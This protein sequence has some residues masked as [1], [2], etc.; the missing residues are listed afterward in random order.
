[1]KKYSSLLASHKDNKEDSSLV[2]KEGV[3]QQKQV[4]NILKSAAL[5]S[6]NLRIPKSSWRSVQDIDNNFEQVL[7]EKES[8][9][10]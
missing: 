6:Q 8:Y 5:D 4:I 2:T 7:A 9:R 10:R 3:E 1:M